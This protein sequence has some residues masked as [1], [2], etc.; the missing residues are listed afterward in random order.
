MPP[1]PISTHEQATPM[2]PHSPRSDRQIA[3]TARAAAAIVL[4]HPL[5]LQLSA[6]S[7]DLLLDLAH[8]DMRVPVTAQESAWLCRAVLAVIEAE[9]VL[10]RGAAP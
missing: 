7:V 3:A 6:I 1:S 9:A 8:R 2:T 4:A 5:A 10:G